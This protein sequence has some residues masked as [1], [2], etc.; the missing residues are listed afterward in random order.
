MSPETIPS[1][2]PGRVFVDVEGPSFQSNYNR[3]PFLFHHSLSAAEP[4]FALPRLRK[5]IENPATRDG[6]YFDS[7]SVRVDQLWKDIPSTQLTLQQAFDGARQGKTWI[8]LRRIQRD[9]EYRALLDQCLEELKTLTHRDI[10]HGT[11][12]RNAIL[13]LTSPGRVTPYHIDRECN[14]LLQIAGTKQISVYDP[15]DREVTTD[16][17]LENFWSKDNNAAVFKPQYQDRA[18]VFWMTPGTG[19]HIPVNSPHWV[20]NGDGLSISLSVAYQYR[21]ADRKYVY[22]ANY[23]M[24]KMGLHPA[25][26]GALGADAAKKALMAL[27]FAG[28]KLLRGP[29]LRSSGRSAA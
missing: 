3:R 27:G 2:H 11:K 9:P 20:K 18:H 22:Q 28:K 1:A 29:K 17:E 6:I 19:V 26:P 23:Y 25:P 21:D 24:R 5:L 8:V 7:G 16:E 10:D 14:S 12:M 4:L 15:D 13:F